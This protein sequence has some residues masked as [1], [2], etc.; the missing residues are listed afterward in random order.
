MNTHK[1]W[2]ASGTV[3]LAALLVLGAVGV[4]AGQEP[5]PPLP[6]PEA[7]TGSLE[8]GEGAGTE[9]QA[10]IMARPAKTMNYQGY[11]TGS[12][13]SPL[14]GAYDMVFSLWD[15]EAAGTGTME[16]GTETHNDVPVSKGLFSVVLGETVPIDPWEDF[17][18]QLYLQITVNGTTLPRQMLRAVPY[19]MG[20]TIG[21]SAIGATVGSGDYGLWVEN[22]NGPGLY[23]NASTTYG[24]FNADVTNSGDGYAGPDTYLFVSPL[25][26]ILPYNASG[27]HLSSEEG[28]MIV[29]ADNAGN[30]T[31][32]IPIQIE[33]PY[34]RDY[35]LRRARV[36][37]RTSEAS[38]TYAAIKGINLTNGTVP[39]IG[40]G[41]TSESSATFDY[42]DIEATDYY[43][44]TSTM[45]PASISFGITMNTSLAYV[46][47]YGVRLQL[48]STY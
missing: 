30:A 48:D 38:I 33:R 22:T 5:E 4:V 43:T 37:F 40:G 31:V 26:A 16:W 10:S 46:H 45:V 36:Y 42:F 9:G 39:T 3:I 12:G 35:L 18:E 7:S 23:V 41:A 44:V 28:Y 24:I 17:D 2:I 34:G 32:R 19:A 47:L 8:V 6:E 11:L 13:S 1:W 25:N 21:A 20:L 14:D 15:A 27:E 29:A